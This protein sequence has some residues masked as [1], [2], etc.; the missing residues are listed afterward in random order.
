MIAA[1]SGQ[2]ARAVADAVK[3]VNANSGNACVRLRFNEDAG[4]VDFVA[5][6]ATISGESFEFISGFDSFG[7]SLRE[8]ADIRA[9]VIQ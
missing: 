8:L 2:I 5:N 6:S 1:P 7:G 9:E 4:E 3:L